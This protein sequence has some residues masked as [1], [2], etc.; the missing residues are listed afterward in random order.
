MSSGSLRRKTKT[1]AKASRLGPHSRSDSHQRS[2]CATY[3]RAEHSHRHDSADSQTSHVPVVP[4]LFSTFR[5]RPLRSR[6][7]GSMST[8]SGRTLHLQP[9]HHHLMV[10][11][12]LSAIS[13]LSGSRTLPHCMAMLIP[14]ETT[15]PGGRRRDQQAAGAERHCLPDSQLSSPVTAGSRC[16]IPCQGVGRQA[17]TQEETCER[18]VECLSRVSGH[19]ARSC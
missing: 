2:P 17:Q 9:G 18:M 5:H 1:F 10:S 11:S 3:T 16:E 6:H 15:G 4:T 7:V 19:G 13:S 12:A 8:F 14:A